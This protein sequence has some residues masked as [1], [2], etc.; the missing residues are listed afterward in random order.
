MFFNW[1]KNRPQ[2]S[3]QDRPS[4]FLRTMALLA[5]LALTAW[6]FWANSQRYT[7][8]FK[9]EARLVDAADV[10]SQEER[11]EIAKII[12]RFDKNFDLR[13]QVHTRRELFTSLNAVDNGILVGFC[14]GKQQMVVF[15]SPLLRQA[16]GEAVAAQM[17]NM[18]MAAGFEQDWTQAAIKSLV[19]LETH[20][21]KIWSRQ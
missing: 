11:A 17:R 8:Q 4:S 20:L 14:P 13:L 18:V 2:S 5:L 16:L 12:L 3:G 7:H 9:A 10:F 21:Q 6:A 15:M 1:F 19:L